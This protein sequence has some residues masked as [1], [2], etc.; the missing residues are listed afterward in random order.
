MSDRVAKRTRFAPTAAILAAVAVAAGL[1]TAPALAEEP[2]APGESEFR[3][4]LI[5]HAEAVAQR[6]VAQSRAVAG[7]EESARLQLIEDAVEGFA[8]QGA[9]AALEGRRVQLVGL[10]QALLQGLQRN[11]S[12]A[13][14]RDV[15]NLSEQ[16][17][18]EAKAVF[19][20]TLDLSFTYTYTDTFDRSRIGLLNIGNFNPG[21][22]FRCVETGRAP[23]PVEDPVTGIINPI[24][25]CPFQ[26]A[27][28]ESPGVVAFAFRVVN[29]ETPGVR[30]IFA[31]QGDENEPFKRSD[32]VVTLNQQFPWGPSVSI[33][34]STRQQE[35]FYRDGFSFDE[36][37]ISANISLSLFTPLPLTRGFGRNNINDASI[38][39][40]ELGLDVGNW[41]LQQTVNSTLLTVNDAY[42]NLVFALEVLHATDQ[43]FALVLDQHRR[44]T[45]RFDQAL[46]TNYEKEQIDAE[47]LAAETQLENARSAFINASLA[48]T[49]LIETSDR[50][51]RE[52]VFLPVGY[53]LAPPPRAEETWQEAM[54]TALATRPEV[55][56]AA[57]GVDIQQIN[58]DVA[59]NETRPDITLSAQVN[60]RT[61]HDV[62]A[63]ANVFEATSAAA[64]RPDSLNTN[65]ALTYNRPLLNRQLD[66]IKNQAEITLED[67]NLNV[68]QVRRQVE[69]EMR[70]AFASLDGARARARSAEDDRDRAREAYEGVVRREGGALEASQFEYIETRRNL[71][72]AEISLASA[73]ADARRAEGALLA[74]Q[75]VIATAFAERTAVSDLDRARVRQLADSGEFRF[76]ASAAARERM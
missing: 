70:D 76:F 11:L 28:R 37:N 3:S 64:T 66:A 13:I 59:R 41:S 34:H 1:S 33:S 43:S 15:P 5:E 18:E 25:D 2:L 73:I 63:F 67:Q 55:Q 40:A 9:W 51:S 30:E 38:R 27:F 14:G 57:L 52:T 26:D 53:G 48:L 71:L 58:V 47:L 49:E 31:S 32:Y 45:R 35:T 72:N 69:R 16:A 23:A 8:G 39:Q 24:V 19:D 50:L 36:A 60:N 74:A 65:F 54:T 56:L 75:G 42:W 17:L 29:A 12:I 61:S 68:V 7:P 22:T 21:T 62:V 10:R 4:T 46:A 6:L 20:P 44:V